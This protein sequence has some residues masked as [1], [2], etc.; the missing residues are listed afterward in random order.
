MR[1]R[2]KKEVTCPFREIKI[3][4][5]EY[6]RFEPYSM[7]FADHPACRF[8]FEVG[9][10]LSLMLPITFRKSLYTS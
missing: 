8:V 6:T 7:A 3:G 4:C 1:A 9:Y 10:V 2:A 5:P